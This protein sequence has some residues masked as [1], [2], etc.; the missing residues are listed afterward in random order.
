MARFLPGVVAAV[1]FSATTLGMVGAEEA[2]KPVKSGEEARIAALG[3]MK[4]DCTVNPAPEVKISEPAAHGVVRITNAKLKTN[5]YPNCPGATIPVKVVFYTSAPGFTGEDRVGLEV[6]FKPGE[7]SIETI[8][9]TV[10]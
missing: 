4:P 10:Q 7:P 2:P 5:R 1:Y 3:S 9:V 8:V 6:S